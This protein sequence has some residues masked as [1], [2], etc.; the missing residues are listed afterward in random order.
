MARATSPL[1]VEA[2]TVK[3]LHF[4]GNRRSRRLSE[5]LGRSGMGHPIDQTGFSGHFPLGVRIT[6]NP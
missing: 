5:A 2:D 4:P 6:E 1:R 3:L